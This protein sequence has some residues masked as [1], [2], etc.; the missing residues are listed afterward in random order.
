MLYR[1][2]PQP[3][4][5]ARCPRAGPTLWSSVSIRSKG[6]PHISHQLISY[7]QKLCR[8][9]YRWPPIPSALGLSSRA[10]LTP[11]SVT[12]AC[13]AP[14]PTSITAS[15]PSCAP[16]PDPTHHSQACVNPFTWSSQPAICWHLATCTI[17][18]L[19]PFDSAQ[20]HRLSASHKPSASH[21]SAAPTS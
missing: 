13:L 15:R 14:A 21:M 11:A 12:R 17:H 6:S 18:S 7:V 1:R 5:R 16:H 10:E 9:Q 20:P 4:L 3:G 2:N 8:M 19:P